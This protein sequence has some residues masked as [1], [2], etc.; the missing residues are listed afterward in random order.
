MMRSFLDELD[1]TG[2]LVHVRREVSTNHEIAAV[3]H[4]LEDRPVVF[5]KVK[6]SGEYR[7]AVGVCATRSIL[8]RALNVK[9]DQLLGKILES[10]EKPKPFQIVD[11]APC[12]EG[13]RRS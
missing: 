3:A 2:D 1:K 7:V 11:R 13:R 5:E 10:I 6:E 4:K 8:A 12:Q 9:G